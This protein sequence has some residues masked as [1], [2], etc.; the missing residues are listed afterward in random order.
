MSFPIPS[1]QFDGTYAFV[2]STKVNEA[3][4]NRA[5]RQ[6]DQCPERRA[7]TLTIINGQAHLP[8]FE[9]TVGYHGELAMIRV[10]RV[11]EGT[12]G[13]AIDRDGTLKARRT[14]G[15]CSY[16]TVWQKDSK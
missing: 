9:G 7:G 15:D 13:G 3:H 4:V 12:V 2:S 11:E 5:T 14:V 8:N 16:D 6:I 10:S 1:T